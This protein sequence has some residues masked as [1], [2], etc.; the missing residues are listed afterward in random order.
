M[1][2][3]KVFLIKCYDMGCTNIYGVFETYEVAETELLK[4]VEV[5]NARIK[6]GNREGDTFFYKR[7]FDDDQGTVL[8]KYANR[9]RVVEIKVYEVNT[10]YD[11]YLGWYD[12]YD[13]DDDEH[14]IE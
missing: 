14:S 8:L 5:L 2:D 1:T 9:H 6:K 10:V 12:Y 11:T 4:L 13:R 3:D 7:D